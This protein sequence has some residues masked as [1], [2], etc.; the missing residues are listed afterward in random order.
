[1][2]LFRE[3]KKQQRPLISRK[4]IHIISCP[5][6]VCAQSCPTLCLCDKLDCSPP[7]PSVHGISQQEHWSGLPFSS[8]G[9]PPNPRI[10]PMS[11]CLLQ[12]RHILYPLSHSGS[13]ISWWNETEQFGSS[14]YGSELQEK[15][16]ASFMR[17]WCRCWKNLGAEIL[18]IWYHR[19]FLVSELAHLA[20]WYPNS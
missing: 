20:S 8:P 12:C 1:M 19:H 10:E 13:P 18:D 2:F 3:K 16:S 6:P 17:I 4:K 7:G 15:Q 9:H 14:F 5:G 11:L